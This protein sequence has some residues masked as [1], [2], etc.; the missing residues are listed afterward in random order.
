ME[1]GGV[2]LDDPPVQHPL[3]GGTYHNTVRWALITSLSTTYL[4][5][6]HGVAGDLTPERGVEAGPPHHHRLRHL[7][8]GLAREVLRK[9]CTVRYFTIRYRTVLYCTWLVT[10]DQSW[11]VMRSGS[12]QTVS[13]GSVSR[14]FFTTRSRN[15]LSLQSHSHGLLCRDRY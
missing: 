5:P 3:Q 8:L 14:F 12:L 15:F 7:H 11:P 4:D 9:Y 1:G 13:P 10:L 6:W 2:V